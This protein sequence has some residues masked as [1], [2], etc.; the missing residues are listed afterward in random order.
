MRIVD[1]LL[2]I[3]ANSF[4]SF[5]PI[6]VYPKNLLSNFSVCIYIRLYTIYI[7][8]RGRGKKTSSL[9]IQKFFI[10]YIYYIIGND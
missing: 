1:I 10:F 3:N 2:I 4:M 6:D 8:V 7:R 5:L 9:M